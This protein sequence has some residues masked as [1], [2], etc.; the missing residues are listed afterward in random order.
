[1]FCS[2]KADNGNYELVT[3]YDPGF[4]AD[5][6]SLIPFGQRVYNRDR[7]TWTVDSRHGQLI[8]SL[9][10]KY[11]GVEPVLPKLA[12]ASTVVGLLEILYIGRSKVRADGSKSAFGWMEQ[13]NQAG[14]CAVIPETAL[15]NF[16]EPSSGSESVPAPSGNYFEMLGIKMDA[17]DQ[18]VKT[19]YRRMV[20]QWHPDVCR[21]P[22]AHE[23]FIGIQRAYEV[24]SDPKLKARYRAGLKLEALAGKAFR[25]K[26]ESDPDD[27]YRSPLK[28]GAILCE[29]SRIGNRYL[30]NRIFNWD[31]IT[32]GKGHTLVS[33]WEQN[34]QEPTYKWI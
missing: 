16:F 31:D 6:K 13:G 20:K 22:D 24:L 15:R 23:I 5:L 12:V 30:I 25:K 10:R 32:D 28:C 29:Y 8:Q 27:F 18:D 2:I 11:F 17:T 14:W 4:V 19:A 21:D 7:K 3:P 9:C 26:V 34:S 1:M 33:S